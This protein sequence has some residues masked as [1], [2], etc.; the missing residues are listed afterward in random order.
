MGIA[1]RNVIKRFGD[2]TAL[3]GITVE[4][5]TGSL[6]AL[7]GPSG[8]GKSTLLRVIAGLEVPGTGT[9][10]L[11]GRDVTGL[12]PQERGIGFVFQHYAAFKH[13]TVADNVAF[14]LTIRKRPK[15]EIRERVAELL[16][17]VQLSPFGDRYPAQLSGGQRQRMALARALAVE[18]SV[19]LLDEPFGALDARVRKELRV[20]LR[21]LHDRSKVTTVIV[22]HDQEE[23]M[24]VAERIVVMNEGRIEQEGGPQELY[25]SPA[26]EFVMSFV[27]PVNR[28]DG[29]LVRPHDVEVAVEPNGATEEAMVERIVHLGFEV[30][31]E[32][33]RADGAPLWAQLTRDQEQELELAEGQIV[34][35]RPARATVFEQRDPPA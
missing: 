2:F 19:L 24:E 12:P 20:W 32:L 4:V 9:V 7:L 18:P 16:A 10:L 14:G 35:V 30:R 5:E 13:M 29:A 8:S 3:D 15:S 11:D 17:L 23:A 25:E 1:A 34:Y 33:V 27:G 28:L 31:V 22:T 21:R 6:T 26:S